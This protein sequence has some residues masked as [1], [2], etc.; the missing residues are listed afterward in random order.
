MK[1]YASIS[2]VIPCYRCADTIDRAVSSVANQTLKPHEIILVE[3]CS[4]DTTLETL[5]QLQT[6]YGQ[7]WIKVIQLK[8]N[9]G[10]GT[11]RNVGWEA[12]EQDYIAFLD[13]D[14]SW[15]PQKIEIQYD[16]MIRNP[17][18]SLTGHKCLQID[19]EETLLSS[20]N[21]PIALGFKRI[22]LNQLLLANRFPTRS[23]MLRN[24]S[25]LR[26]PTFQRYSE[27]YRLWLEFACSGQ[28]CYLCE[29]PLAYL[30]KS[31]YGAAGLSSNLWAMQKGE[32][33]NYHYLYKRGYLNIFKVI[34]FL[35]FSYLKFINRV[36]RV[37]F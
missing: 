16:F 27:D 2:V 23:V 3:D 9:S 15:H 32:A 33:D 21:I 8:E 34:F 18:V 26:F 24:T 37:K 5:Y 10:P 7:N 17:N 4:G 11:A 29:Y 31:D 30:Y 6:R 14:D 35:S 19:E 13:S 12:S 22:G 25:N 28:E 20:Q 1:K 36:V